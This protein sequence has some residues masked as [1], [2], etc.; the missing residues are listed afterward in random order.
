MSCFD[1]A[2]LRRGA[3]ALSMGLLSACAF[4]QPPTGH[5]DGL[6]GV[7]AEA[8]APVCQIV[9]TRQGMP[10]TEAALK[11][12]FG[13]TPWLLL[14]EAHDNPHHHRLRA[15]WLPA[16][17][18][19]GAG[20]APRIVFEHFDREHD[21]AL[22]QAQQDRPQGPVAAW[23]QA[24]QFDARA[25]QGERYQPLFDAAFAVAQQA[26]VRWVAGNFS[27]AEARATL[28]RQQPA[29]PALLARQDGAT[30]DVAAGQTLLAAV[31]TGH[32]N[33]LP[34]EALT[35]MVAA[36]RLRDA[37]LA[38]ALQQGAGRG[39][40]LAG[41]GHV[42]RRH[43]VPRYLDAGGQQQA[44]VVGLVSMPGLEAGA[45]Q[46]PEWGAGVAAQA[47]PLVPVGGDGRA[48]TAG[49]RAVGTD[50]LTALVGPVRAAELRA[51]YDVVVFTLPPPGA[52]DHCAA[53]RAGHEAARPARGGTAAP[54]GT[55]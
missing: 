12:R 25:W 19:G 32:C 23:V 30:W 41:N 8:P 17:V 31:R 50:V 39:L 18:A 10:M 28:M 13:E 1:P 38:Q 15:Q 42:D 37:A 40:L 34:D 3:T 47:A 44:L 11:R 9:D 55:P 7:R 33:A 45:R 29:D 24:A 26:G 14:G 46:C 22:M 4:F 51:A 36:Q 2:W 52:I 48:D 16:W 54:S 6:D 20:D 5:P 49:D 43:G 35:P 21:A 53:F 27:R